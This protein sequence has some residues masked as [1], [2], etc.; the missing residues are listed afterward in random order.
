MKL[1]RI[2]TLIVISV[3]IAFM[4]ICFIPSQH[5]VSD[6]NY[7][8]DSDNARDMANVNNLL[9]GNLINDPNYLGAYR[10][11]NPL[12]HWL[13]AGAVLVTSIPVNMVVSK[14][15]PYFNLLAPVCFFLMVFSL[16]DSLV[17]ISAIAGFLFFIS[18]DIPGYFS[19]TYTPWLYPIAF[20]QFAFYLGIIVLYNTFLK[21]TFSWFILLGALAGFMFLGHTGPTAIFMLQIV[22][23]IIVTAYNQ[24]RKG[25]LLIRPLVFKCLATLISFIIVSLPLTIIVFGFYKFKMV[26]P[27]IY[28]YTDPLFQLKNITGLLKA[29]FSIAFLVA[30]AGLFFIIKS[31][32]NYIVKNILYSWLFSS[33]L[34]YSYVTLSKYIRIHY[35]LL[36][37]G[38]VPSFHFFFYFKAV[39][40]VFFGI[41]FVELAK[42][43]VNFI[44]HLIAS[45]N[46]SVSSKT[47]PIIIVALILLVVIYYPAYVNRGDFKSVVPE[48]ISK[49]VKAER[50]ETYHW[51][52]ANTKINDVVLCQED[53]IIFPL[54]ASGRKMVANT[55]DHTNPYLDFASREK[56]RDAMLSI[57]MGNVTYSDSLFYKY[58]VD[59]VFVLNSIN[60][61][62][63]KNY[64][65]KKVFTTATY[66]IYAK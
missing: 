40:S 18:G 37:P 21:N 30:L 51:L 34:L 35:H 57:L 61:S 9:A 64:F 42:R 50:I 31:D 1:N 7:G 29:N 38:I 53:L 3:F 44:D 39:E 13:E 22:W 66:S 10:W 65:P 24:I 33:L 25:E 26:N 27:A 16:F 6:I 55:K 46:S 56:D 48:Q 2:T 12:V 28:E 23:L 59:Y 15:G 17:A 58:K 49:A 63:I 47:N 60:Y 52:I 32:T 54:M 5:V 14:G 8:Y 45:T 19:A 20:V 11:Y 41:G 36:L 4:I 62:M 43:V